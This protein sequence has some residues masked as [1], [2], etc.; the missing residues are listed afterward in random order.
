MYTHKVTSVTRPNEASFKNKNTR[1]TIARDGEITS[2]FA[3]RK[4]CKMTGVPGDRHLKGSCNEYNFLNE[5]I[6]DAIS[7]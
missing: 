1:V 3:P 4:R 2:G 6:V 5:K 7:A